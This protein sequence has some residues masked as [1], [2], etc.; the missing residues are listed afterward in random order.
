MAGLFESEIWTYYLPQLCQTVPVIRHAAAAVA[1]RHECLLHSHAAPKEANDSFALQ[2]YNKAIGHLMNHIST[3]DS[4]ID[5]TILTCFLFVALEML[6]GNPKE[7]L[8]HMQGGVQM[9]HQQGHL[10]G[11]A[12]GFPENIEKEILHLGLRLNLQ[13]SFYGRPLTQ[14]EW[15][16]VD[17]VSAVNSW[18]DISQARYSLDLLMNKGLKLHRDVGIERPLPSFDMIRQQ[19]RIMNEL[20]DWKIKFDR[21]MKIPRKR[22]T[23]LDPR[24]PLQLYIQH[25]VSS[26]FVQ[27]CLNRDEIGYDNHNDAFEEIVCNA[28]KWMH[29]DRDIRQEAIKHGGYSD[30]FTFEAGIIPM[31]YW[32]ATKCRS[33]V[34]RRRAIDV[35]RYF[36]AR[37][38]LWKADYLS[39][40]ATMV[41]D[42][43]EMNVNN[44]PIEKRVP[45]DK[46]RAYDVLL[47]TGNEFALPR[48]SNAELRFKPDGCDGPWAF[49]LMY[50]SDIRD[51]YTSSNPIAR[52]GDLTRD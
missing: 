15:N 41:A 7:A 43:E 6:C 18:P 52:N 33:P 10:N 9:L 40:V 12:S 46:D 29:F 49:K 39:V 20:Q 47:R 21:L 24:M 14:F 26:V 35:L 16:S 51:G 2:Q 27:T 34:I 48:G 31:A 8:N 32:T 11:F 23:S 30:K 38:G 25:H 5:F 42:I 44:L 3:K 28:E 45:S 1:A 36:P 4:K 19:N 37:E 13:L 50:V 17:R 22:I